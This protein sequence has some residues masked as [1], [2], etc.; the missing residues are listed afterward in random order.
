M[1]LKPNP[2]EGFASQVYTIKPSGDQR[3]SCHDKQIMQTLTELI[4][5]T[6]HALSL[7]T[8]QFQPCPLATLPQFR[9][10]HRD[11][12]L[13]AD[14]TPRLSYRCYWFPSGRYNR[15]HL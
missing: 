13:R 6:E 4:S 1:R 5:I 3:E 7:E 15:Q 9:T 12:P 8:S 10:V 14:H 11:A 2:D